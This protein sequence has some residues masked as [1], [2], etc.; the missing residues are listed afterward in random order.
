MVWKSRIPAVLKNYWGFTL[1]I[2]R[3]STLNASFSVVG[4]CCGL[5]RKLRLAL[6]RHFPTVARW[7]L[8]RCGTGN[9]LWHFTWGISS[10][11]MVPGMV[12][13]SLL[14]PY[15]VR[16][17]CFVPSREKHQTFL[18]ILTVDSMGFHGISRKNSSQARPNS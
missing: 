10:C 1:Q 3:V 16:Q 2:S 6:H 17:M 8:S 14:R 4:T 9:S 18:A 13:F 12:P 15:S 5:R 11:W 7:A